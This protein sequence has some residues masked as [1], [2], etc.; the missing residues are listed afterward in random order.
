ML[1]SFRGAQFDT[2]D[3]AHVLQYM[4][5]EHRTIT[6][7]KRCDDRDENGKHKHFFKRRVT[8][9]AHKLYTA[10]YIFYTAGSNCNSLTSPLGAAVAIKLRW[11]HAR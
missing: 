10:Y 7:T 1:R 5:F 6:K 8:A 3:C 9:I 4:P 2:E 11:R